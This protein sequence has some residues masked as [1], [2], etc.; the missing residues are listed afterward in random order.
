MS[1]MGL[2]HVFKY[3]TDSLAYALR[4]SSFFK[5]LVNYFTSHESTFPNVS[6]YDSTNS[7]DC[8]ASRTDPNRGEPKVRW[9]PFSAF[10]LPRFLSNFRLFNRYIYSIRNSKQSRGGRVKLES[11]LNST[12]LAFF[13]KYN[14]IPNWYLYLL[15]LIRKLQNR[16]NLL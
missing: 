2:G 15:L 8:T 11:F 9:I 7:T 10:N 3:A 5:C 4:P 12:G 6:P 1:T 13:R 16:A 14:M